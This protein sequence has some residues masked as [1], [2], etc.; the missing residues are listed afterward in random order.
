[1]KPALQLPF[2]SLVVLLEEEVVGQVVEHHGVGVVD[3]VGLGELLDA[4][5]DGLLALRVQV[6]DGEAHQRAHAPA[7]ELLRGERG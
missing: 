6:E 1:M 7:V 5:L 3:G 4:L 2:A